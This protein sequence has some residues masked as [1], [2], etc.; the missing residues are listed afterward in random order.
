MPDLV[1]QTY[2][3]FPSPWDDVAARSIPQSMRDLLY[4]CEQLYITNGAYRQAQ[5]RIISYFLT[6]IE[7]MAIDNDHPLSDDERDKHLAFLNEILD[8]RGVVQRA[9]QNLAAY[10]NA[11]F[12]LHVPFRRYL[13]C[14]N[15]TC[16]LT[17]P[18]RKLAEHGPARLSV[19]AQ[20][21]MVATCPR[22][23]ERGT[24]EINDLPDDWEKTLSVKFW[25]PHEI[26]IVYDWFS[27]ATEYLWR[28]PDIYKQSIR[29]GDTL[30]LENCPIKVLQAIRQ[31]QKFR[32]YPG[33]LYH[34]KEPTLAGLPVK[35]WGVPRILSHF[36]TLYYV[37]VL[38]RYNQAIALDYIVPLRVLTPA[39]RGGASF[40]QGAEIDPLLMLNAGD[41]KSQVLAMLRD[42]RRD[43]MRWNFLPFPIQYQIIGGDARALAPTELVKLGYEQLFTESGVPVEIQQAT[44]SLQTAPVALRLFESNHHTIVR[45]NNAILQFLVDRS[46]RL[47]GQSPYRARFR[48]VTFSDDF[49][50][51]MAVIQMAMTGV[52]SRSTALRMLGLEFRDEARAIGEE[53]RYERRIQTHMQDEAEDEEFADQILSGTAL[54]PPGAA[55]PPGAVPAPGGPGGPS[56]PGQPAGPGAVAGAAG[57]GPVAATAPS[58]NQPISLEELTAQADAIARDLLFNRTETQRISELRALKQKNETLHAAVRSKIDAIRTQAQREGGIMLLGQ[59]PPRPAQ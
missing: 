19:D 54:L 21:N 25:S 43:P 34:L 30:A 18:L 23:G 14:G 56:S 6:D 2:D 11:F 32:F 46:T 41:M 52:V 13:M 10:G 1:S 40:N 44:L 29:R 5:E 17:L 42:R 49:Q 36:R 4:L 55:P 26:E 15:R 50:K 28:I 51:T 24:W 16:R 7:V 35:G 58:G 39:P 53:S 22:C 20:L 59:Q 45:S 3:R 27:G 33:V 38:H 12:S 48:R 9:Q 31:G 8:V 57:A 47:L 37:Q